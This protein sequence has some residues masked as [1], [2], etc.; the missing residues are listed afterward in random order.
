M[1][2][3]KVEPWMCTLDSSEASS[4]L[5][6]ALAA[7]LGMER[8]SS[9]EEE[10][11]L[12]GGDEGRLVASALEAM[13]VKCDEMEAAEEDNEVEAGV[14]KAVKSVD[15]FEFGGEESG[16]GASSSSEVRDLTNVSELI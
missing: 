4:R 9:E 8:L 10:E 3:L 11:V 13:R 7:L 1:S 14:K 15:G 16:D 12:S 2:N 6:Q 5:V